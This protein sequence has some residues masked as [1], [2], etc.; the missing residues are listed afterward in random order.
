MA[1]ITC[2]NCGKEISN[3]VVRCPGCKVSIS[4]AAGL[5]TVETGAND[6]SMDKSTVNANASDKAGRELKKAVQ[7]QENLIAS[8]K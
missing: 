3:R 1:I 7:D 4:V 5:T 8:I 2:A 6:V